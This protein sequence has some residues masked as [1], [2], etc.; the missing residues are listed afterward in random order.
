MLAWF[1]FD[2][3]LHISIAASMH[4]TS[5]SGDSEITF[6]YAVITIS[7]LRKYPEFSYS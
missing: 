1:L 6:L 7:M 5:V 4:P 2:L 3:F